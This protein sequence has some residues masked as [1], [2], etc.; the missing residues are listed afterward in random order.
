LSTVL[1]TGASGFIGSRLVPVLAERHHVVS[2]SRRPG[3]G[4]EGEIVLGAFHSQEDLRKL[5]SRVDALI[6]LAAATGGRDEDEALRVNVV[7]TVRL[8]RRL[9]DGGCAKFV[10][11]SSIAAVGCLDEQFVPQALPIPDD[12]PCLAR[13]AYGASKALMEEAA[14]YCQR[15]DP[16]SDFVVFRLGAVAGSSDAQVTQPGPRLARPFVSLARIQVDDVIGALVRAVELPCRPGFRL[17]NL[18]GPDSDCAVPVADVLRASLGE[19]A[20]ALDLRS[21]ETAGGEF[22]PVYAIGAV[23]EALGFAPT[24]SNRALR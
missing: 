24:L 17:L 9:I 20:R 12:H 21:Y 7:G 14:A 19:R 18:V 22:A 4:H 6:H 23:R 11:A 2:L 8:L 3:P 1:V 16:G 15:R 5:P 10:L 13:D